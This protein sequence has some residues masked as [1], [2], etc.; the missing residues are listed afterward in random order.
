MGLSSFQS[1]FKG[2]RILVTG[3]TGFKGSW[4]CQW[5]LMLGAEVKGY[6]LAPERAP[7]HFDLLNL[8]MDSELGD[9]R[10][11]EQTARI[12]R[13]FRPEFVFHLASQPLVKRSYEDPEE[14][15]S[16]NV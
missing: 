14:T 10:N 13:I 5:L 8:P 1:A 4:L 11:R 6:A 9:I 12:I 7:N 15:F 2:R 16:T 3:H